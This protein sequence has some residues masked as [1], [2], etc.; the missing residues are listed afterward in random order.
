MPRNNRHKNTISLCYAY[1]FKNYYYNAFKYISLNYATGPK[2]I[3]EGV[4]SN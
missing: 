4:R 2:L 1:S 3:H